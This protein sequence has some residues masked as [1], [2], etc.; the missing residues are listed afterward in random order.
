MC[1]SHWGSTHG[2]VNL[3][4]RWQSEF[5]L[6][7]VLCVLG[8]GVALKVH[9]LK[10]SSS[11][12]L[13]NITPVLQEVVVELGEG[14]GRVGGRSWGRVGGELGGGRCVQHTKYTTVEPLYRGHCWD[15]AG[16]PYREVS[17]IQR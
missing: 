8:N 14:W 4:E 17:L 3:C 2:S 11:S 15:L 9:S 5:K 7:P 16:C 6:S 12:E 13:V 1:T 10:V